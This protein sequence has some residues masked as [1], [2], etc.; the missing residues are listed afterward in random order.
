M[1]IYGGEEK[2]EINKA[3]FVF[4]LIYGTHLVC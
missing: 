4:V 1:K 2:I 3:F